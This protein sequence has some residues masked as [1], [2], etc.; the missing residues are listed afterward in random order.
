[1]YCTTPPATSLMWCAARDNLRPFTTCFS[2]SADF[3]VQL[4]G[5]AWPS[6]FRPFPP[7]CCRRARGGGM[8][9]MQDLAGMAA[10]D[11]AVDGE[12]GVVDK[13]ERLPSNSQMA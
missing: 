4:A 2:A 13:L 11:A 9:Q 5:G 10:S 8:E 3:S 7:V 12:L 6:K 1:M